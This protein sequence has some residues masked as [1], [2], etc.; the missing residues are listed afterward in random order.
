MDDG[1]ESRTDAYLDALNERIADLQKQY[2]ERSSDAPYA[3]LIASDLSQ[4]YE[5]L[6]AFWRQRAGV[7]QSV[8]ISEPGVKKLEEYSW[9]PVN[10]RAGLRE[11]GVETLEQLARFPQSELIQIRGV[12]GRNLEMIQYELCKEGYSLDGMDRVF[13]DLLTEA[14][15]SYRAYRSL[16]RAG[17]GSISKVMSVAGLNYVAEL[18]GVKPKKADE[19]RKKVV[20]PYASVLPFKVLRASPRMENVLE[21][22]KFETLGDIVQKSGEEIL[23]LRNCGMVVLTELKTKLG[24]FGLKLRED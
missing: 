12:G 6:S 5:R 23:A 7:P 11:K 2:R 4:N 14:K 17:F 1:L 19:I 24:E 22:C 9:L 13:G 8:Q 21:S 3:R 15:L 18:D 16:V 10:V 20:L